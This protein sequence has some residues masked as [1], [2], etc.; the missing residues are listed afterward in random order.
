MGLSGGSND[1]KSGLTRVI[2]GHIIVAVFLPYCINSL[3]TRGPLFCVFLSSQVLKSS[4]TLLTLGAKVLCRSL[5][6]PKAT[7][8]QIL[9]DSWLKILVLV[10]GKYRSVIS[11][12]DQYIILSKVCWSPHLGDLPFCFDF[13]NFFFDI[14]FHCVAQ[15]GHDL[16]C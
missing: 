8:A 3:E 15:A 16:Q 7:E 6:I 11:Y 13:C 5:I 1:G 12:I 14:G 9:K 4:L 10:F 2:T